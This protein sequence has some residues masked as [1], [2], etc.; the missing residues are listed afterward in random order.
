M[1]SAM[2]T[3]DSLLAA[4]RAAQRAS[5]TPEQRPAAAEAP[6][7]A[8]PGFELPRELTIATVQQTRAALSAW[9]SQ[10]PAGQAWCLAASGVEQVDAAGVQWLLA[11]ASRAAQDY[12][13]LRV[14]EPSAALIAACTRLGLSEV[15]LETDDAR[16]RS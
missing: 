14:L 12:V 5:P 11:L 10:R 8:A 2:P 13:R 16:R 3:L 15:L 7:V 1:Q 9:L 6:S 4:R